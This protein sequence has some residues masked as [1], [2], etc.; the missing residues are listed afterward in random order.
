LS[1]ATVS[2]FYGKVGYQ[3]MTSRGCP[4]QCSYCINSTLRGMYHG[5]KYVRFRSVDA[6]IEECTSILRRFPFVDYMWF[7]D[8][9]FF[10]R[11]QRDLER[12]ATLYSE[13]VGLPF[14]L[15]ASPVTLTEDKY[16]PLIDAGLHTVQMGIETGSASTQQ[17]FH[18][19]RMSNDKVLR[20]AEIIARHAD[21]TQTPYYDII[22]DVPWEDDRNRRETLDLVSRLPK[23]FKL[24]LF[25]LVLYPATVAY[26]RACDEGL[27]RDE[28]AQIYDHMYTVRNDHYLNLVLFLAA[29]GR[30]P[31][32]LVKALSDERLDPLVNSPVTRPLG[33]ASRRVLHTVRQVRDLARS[34]R[35]RDALFG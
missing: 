1:S 26:D 30:T 13:R 19:E 22:I 17:V 10:A 28:K 27:V 32:W 20:A 16:K 8:D 21:Q 9:V 15:L 2:A 12:F 7:S 4:H 11:P 25:S 3:T 5:Q 29:K 24:Q 14:Y 6:V 18:R 23:P 33:E 35:R 34:H 31:G